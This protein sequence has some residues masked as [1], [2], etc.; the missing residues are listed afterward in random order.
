MFFKLVSR[1]SMGCCS[2]CCS[3]VIVVNETDQDVTVLVKRSKCF[4]TACSAAWQNFFQF[5]ATFQ[6]CTRLL[7]A[8]EKQT[9]SKRSELK[10]TYG[11]GTNIFLLTV[12]D[13]KGQNIFDSVECSAGETKQIPHNIEYVKINGPTK[14]LSQVSPDRGHY[15]NLKG[16]VTP[17]SQ[18]K[19]IKKMPFDQFSKLDGVVLYE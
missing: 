9:C 15:K 7:D 18:S 1:Q 19:V 14:Y 16:T 8:D 2:S 13:C 11:C 17:V 4:P 5:N 10:L 3:N 6:E 12:I